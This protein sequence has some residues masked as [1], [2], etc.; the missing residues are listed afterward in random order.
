MGC[1]SG[2]VPHTRCTGGVAAGA[3]RWPLALRQAADPPG[4]FTVASHLHVLVWLHAPETL[5]TYTRL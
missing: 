4:S 2:G 1:K 3:S 5:A